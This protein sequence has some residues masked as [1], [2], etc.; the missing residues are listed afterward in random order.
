M[1]RYGID[2]QGLLVCNVGHPDN[3][4]TA[5]KR[6]FLILVFLVPL[7]LSSCQCSNKPDIGPVE[8]ENA[9]VHSEA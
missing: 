6:F 4:F 5:M 7:W 1:L 9:S 8:D 3:P 2:K